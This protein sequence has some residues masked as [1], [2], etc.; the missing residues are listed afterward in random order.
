MQNFG[1][2][3][4]EA[5][6]HTPPGGKP[7]ETPGPLSLRSDC[8]DREGSIKGSQAAPKTG[9]PW[10]DPS[11]SRTGSIDEGKG[12]LGQ[13]AG[14]CRLPLLNPAE[15]AQTRERT[16]LLYKNDPLIEAA[17]TARS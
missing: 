3:A 5:L 6:P 9:A 10:T 7:P 1:L 14:M 16:S 2:G 12:A 11:R 8:R 15:W 4:H 13:A 17:E